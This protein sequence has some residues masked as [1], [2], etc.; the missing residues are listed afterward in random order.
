[1]RTWRDWKAVVA[2]ACLLGWASGCGGHR[3]V[4]VIETSKGTIVVE[5]HEKD[6]PQH[7]ANFK[8]LATE[9]LYRGTTF[10][11]IV[12][13]FVIQGGDPNSK[14]GD[15]ANDGQG[16]T[17]YTIPAEINRKHERGA[18]AAARQGDAYNPTRA[19]SGSQ[20]YICLQPLDMLDGQYTVYGKVIEGM[21]V[22]D[23]IALRPRITSDPHLGEQPA[24]KVVIKD[25]RVEKR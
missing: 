3:E 2:L 11:R 5:L 12:P 22:V 16:G 6:A 24:E 23:A 21:E 13:G 4:G 18:L 14:D 19:S 25:V 10:H 15:L 7:V 17:G 1:M 20:F 8:K 9:G